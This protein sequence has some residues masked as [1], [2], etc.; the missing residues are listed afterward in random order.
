MEIFSGIMWT[1]LYLLGVFILG[2]VVLKWLVRA[3]DEVVRKT[4]HIGYTLSVFL[5]IELFDPWTVS[6]AVILGFMVVIFF[7]ALLLE[8]TP[9][10]HKLLVDRRKEGGEIKYSVLLGFLSFAILIAVFGNLLP[11]GD[12]TIVV[13]AV[14]GWSLGDALAALVGKKFGHR[15]LILPFAD[16]KKTTEGSLAMF[17]GIFIVFL[18]ILFFYGGYPW[19][20]TLVMSAVVAAVSTVVEAI[21]KK[22]TDTLFLPLFGALTLYLLILLLNVNGVV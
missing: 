9:Y 14:V 11:Y 3:S 21:A 10:Y 22:G 13:I 6:V 8:K 1:V 17:T 16:P 2:T 5:F 12:E 4:H 18:P 19:W 20:A 7:G 15:R